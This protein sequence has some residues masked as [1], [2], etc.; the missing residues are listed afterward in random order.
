MAKIK[1]GDLVRVK[2]LNDMYMWVHVLFDS[3]FIVKGK[4]EIDPYNYFTF[5]HRVIWSIYT[6]KYQLKKS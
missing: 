1:I 2:L 3:Q 6:L 4:R 5:T